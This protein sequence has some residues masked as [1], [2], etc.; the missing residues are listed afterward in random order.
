MA[1]LA[2]RAALGPTLA[3][4]PRPEPVDAE[5]VDQS[6]PGRLALVWR[7]FREDYVALAALILLALLIAVALAAPLISTYLTGF[8]PER[9]SLLRALRPPGAPNYLGTDE[10]GRDV[11]TR[12]VYGARVS[13]GVA[14]LTVAIALSLGAFLGS[15]AGYYGGWLDGL[16]MRSVD[17]LQSIPSLFI[18]IFVSVIFNVGPVSLAFV[19]ASLSWTGISR[20]VRAEVLSLRSRDYVVAAR[21]LGAGDRRLILRHIIPNVVPVMIV[22]ATLAVGNV[23]LAEA[24][25]SYLGLGVQP[26]TPSWGNMLTNAQQYIFRSITLAFVPGVAILL[27]VLSVNVVGNALRDALDPRLGRR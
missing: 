22:W 21:A 1:E 17:A 14:G 15:V 11:L 7:R 27:T 13:L 18:L 20:L 9:Q 12:L 16:I 5:E 4:A 19:I 3:S 23:I 8:A 2:P 25:L 10:L 6:E 26:P 24:T